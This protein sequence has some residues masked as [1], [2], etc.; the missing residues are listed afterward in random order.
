MHEKFIDQGGI[1]YYKLN[2]LKLYCNGRSR[3]KEFNDFAFDKGIKISLCDLAT[4][5]KRGFINS[6]GHFVKIIFNY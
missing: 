5:Q 1:F 6:L 2:L 3:Y 4:L